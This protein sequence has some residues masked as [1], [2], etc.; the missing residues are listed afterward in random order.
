M[1][2]L[3][4]KPTLLIDYVIKN[5]KNPNIFNFTMVLIFENPTVQYADIQ[6]HKKL[7]SDLVFGGQIFNPNYMKLSDLSLR[8]DGLN[9]N[10]YAN[11]CQT[12][13]GLEK[14]TYIDMIYL[15]NSPEFKD[16]FKKIS[17]LSINTNQAEI[18]Y[19]LTHLYRLIILNKLNSPTTNVLDLPITD[20]LDLHDDFQIINWKYRDLMMY[21]KIFRKYIYWKVDGD[22]IICIYN[23]ILK[24][25]PQIWTDIETFIDDPNEWDYRILSELPD[26]TLNVV[27][28]HIYKKWDKLK[29]F[30]HPNINKSDIIS[31]IINLK[32]NAPLRYSAW[33][34]EISSIATIDNLKKY[35]SIDWVWSE[36]SHS[37]Y[38]T[39]SDIL[40]NPDLPWWFKS[41]SINPNITIDFILTFYKP[42][43]LTFY[44]RL[45]INKPNQLKPNQLK[46][47]QLKP[48]Q[49][50]NKQ[51]DWYE[52]SQNK[53]IKM[54]DV[55]N[56]PSLPWDY[57]G[58]SNN[59][60]LTID[61][62]LKNQS[63]KWDIIAISKNKFT[64]NPEIY[65]NHIKNS[66]S[67]LS[68]IIQP[69][70]SLIIDYV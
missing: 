13:W 6:K 65:N 9:P 68:Y 1:G 30:N 15:V 25:K 45:G 19:I 42:K 3:C 46:P 12:I 20:V 16:F 26:L 57:G 2:I 47:N 39:M 31:M 53:G 29:I 55:I 33:M 11:L 4:D 40:A 21:K 24:T 44:E 70:T 60:N 58:L 61:F 27:I 59:I 66:M 69:L 51:F 8:T 17:N 49:L 34:Y 48:D 62:I 36:V 52:I 63:K 56:N 28:K 67:K 50:K 23:P 35:P 32:L 10:Y 37:K 38:I 41:V 54:E 43:S 64:Y 22:N 14:F 18:A 5:S 7:C